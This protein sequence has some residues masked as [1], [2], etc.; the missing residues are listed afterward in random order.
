MVGVKANIA[1]DKGKHTRKTIQGCCNRGARPELRLKSTLLKQSIGGEREIMGQGKVTSH[2]FTRR[3][4]LASWSEVPADV[5]LL[6][7]H[8]PERWRC[9][10]LEG[11]LLKRW[12]PGP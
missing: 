6:L 5:R 12:L 2:I 3:G 10:L 11:L 8:R 1:P 7:S 4:S 9:D